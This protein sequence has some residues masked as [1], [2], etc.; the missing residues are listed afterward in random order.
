MKET[1]QLIPIYFFEAPFFTKFGI[2]MM[3][4]SMKSEPFTN[5]TVYKYLWNETDPMVKFS[6]KVAPSL[7]PTQNVG[8]L[9]R[10]SIYNQINY[11]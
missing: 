10:V 9:A 2:N 1:L 7:V 5:S 3:M 8:V 4:R 6:Q 11:G